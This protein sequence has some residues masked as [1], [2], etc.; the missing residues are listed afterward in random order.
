MP[1]FGEKF[2]PAWAMGA[3]RSQVLYFAFGTSHFGRATESHREAHLSAKE[4]QAR[5][6]ARLPC[7]HAHPR[8]SSDAQAP[9]PQAPQAPVRIALSAMTTTPRQ[10][11]R[12]RRQRLSRS[13]EFERVYRQGKSFGNRQLVLYAFPNANTHR[14]RLGLSVSRKVGG[15]VER[16]RVKRL[17]REAFDGLEE[18]LPDGQDVVVVARPSSLQLAEREGLQGL[19][20][21]LTELLV[22]AG[23]RRD[24]SADATPR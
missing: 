2:R 6:D 15:S 3:S 12:G 1:A 16:N 5:Q 19:T 10:E 7:S 17:L 9:P 13:A 20:S 14:P 11:S 4:T 8:R 24:T 22:R 23:L 21:S 18:S